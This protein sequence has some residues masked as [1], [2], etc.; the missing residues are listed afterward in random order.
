[1]GYWENGILGLVTGDAL[2]VPVEFMSREEIKMNPVR[3]IM[4][5]GTYDVPAGSWSDDSS[6]TLAELASL[7]ESKKSESEKS[8]ENEE[9]ADL[10]GSE[11]LIDLNDIMRRF[12]AWLDHGEYTP[13]GEAFDMGNTCS[14]AIAR[15]KEGKDVQ[16]CGSTGEN[17]NGNGSLMRILPVCI[18]LWEKQE[19]L[20]LTDEEA[21]NWVHRIS[22]L[23][24]AHI[25]SK[26]ACGIYY[27]CVREIL[28]YK[29]S[30]PKI[31]ISFMDLL[32]TGVRK[33]FSFYSSRDNFP[34][35]ELY[36]YNRLRNLQ[37]LA[38][39]DVSTIFSSGY[40]VHTITAAFW[41]LITTTSYRECVLKAV[42]LGNDTDTTAAVAGGLA[43]LYYGEKQIPGEWLSRIIRI[44][45]IGSLCRQ[46]C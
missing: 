4:G 43:G 40:V 30:K 19:T 20:N 33:A 44:D 41:C 34:S 21:V 26:I 13:Q 27:F 45:W 23:T 7:V 3:D 2:G 32:Q 37:S 5:F 39:A 1:M 12:A 35:K 36:Y 38:D 24:H 25:R 31:G 10:S 28:N 46:L 15:F 42:N 17:S 14:T 22:A 29:Q 16:S 6:M 8:T 18:Y 9:S 11:S